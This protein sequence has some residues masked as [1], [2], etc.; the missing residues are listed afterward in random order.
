MLLMGVDLYS[1]RV[2]GSSFRLLFVPE[3]SVLSDNL[4]KCR[5]AEY[6]NIRFDRS[7]CDAF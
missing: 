2:H 6:Q 3:M 1:V 7:V 5:W 4:S